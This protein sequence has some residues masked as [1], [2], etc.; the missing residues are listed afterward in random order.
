MKVLRGERG[1]C[2]CCLTFMCCLSPLSGKRPFVAGDSGNQRTSKHEIDASLSGTSVWRPQSRYTASRTVKDRK[3]TA[4]KLC[5]KDFAERLG[6]LSG[7]ICLKTSVLLGHDRI[8]PRIVQKILWC[9]SCDSLALWV[10]FGFWHRV[11]HQIPAES[12]MSRQNRATAPQ[13]KVSHLSPDPP[14]VALSSSPRVSP[15]G[16]PKT[17][18]RYTGNQD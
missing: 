7:A 15:R 12:E 14:P 9:C 10:L 4:K 2:P 13:I 5:D 16:P 6:E 1:R 3:G 18:E 8:A 11:S 17:S